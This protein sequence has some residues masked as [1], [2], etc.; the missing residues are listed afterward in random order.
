MARPTGA[1]GAKNEWGLDADEEDAGVAAPSSRDL[2][3]WRLLGWRKYRV[4]GLFVEETFLEGV[5]EMKINLAGRNHKGEGFVVL[6]ALFCLV[7]LAIGLSPAVRAQD[8]KGNIRGTVT[9]EQGAAVVGAEV[10]V[11]DPATG[12]SRRATTGGDGVYNFPDLPLGSFN[13]HVAHPGF[14]ASEETGIALHAA[15]SL[16]FN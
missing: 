1:E 8:V 3:V 5:F 12:F 14:K 10:I 4:H 9:D 2:T 11:N 6:R 13:L 7:V 15:D 16:V